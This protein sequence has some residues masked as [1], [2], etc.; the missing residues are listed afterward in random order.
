MGEQG[1]QCSPCKVV[2]ALVKISHV[3]S[4]DFKVNSSH[5]FA[6][7][8]LPSSNDTPLVLGTI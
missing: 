3:L 1:G 4:L 5:P 7:S 6:D 8:S 2:F